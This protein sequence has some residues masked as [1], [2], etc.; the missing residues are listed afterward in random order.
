MDKLKSVNSTETKR[1]VSGTDLPSTQKK[2][3]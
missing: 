1:K 2:P 3:T